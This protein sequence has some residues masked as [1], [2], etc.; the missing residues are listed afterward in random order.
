MSVS[1]LRDVT[2]RL[3]VPR[4][5]VL[6]WPFGHPLGEPFNRPQQLTIIRDAL[7]VLCTAAPGTIVSLPYR[8][9][10]HH[11]VELLDWAFATAEETSPR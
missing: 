8:W 6:R 3:H 2:E 4:A 10:R 1:L 9:R 7:Y 5:V 11:F